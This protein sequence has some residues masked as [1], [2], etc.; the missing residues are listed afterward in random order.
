MPL[1]NDICR[2][3]D[4]DCPSREI[5][6]RYLQRGTGRRLMGAPTNRLEPCGANCAS[7]GPLAVFLPAAHGVPRE[8]S[9]RA[10]RLRGK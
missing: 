3:H 9:R 10:F 6:E 8:D 2:C 5:C 4:D 7:N 1:S